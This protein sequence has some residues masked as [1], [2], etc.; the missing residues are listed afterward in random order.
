V[1]VTNI[2][3]IDYANGEVKCSCG[4]P[5]QRIAVLRKKVDSGKVLWYWCPN[6]DEGKIRA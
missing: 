5:L 2:R 3:R 6:C 1:S 4:Q